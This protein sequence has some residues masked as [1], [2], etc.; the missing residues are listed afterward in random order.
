MLVVFN[1]AGLLAVSMDDGAGTS[2]LV[3]SLA[4]AEMGAIGV[5]LFF[6]ISGFVMALSARRFAGPWGASTFLALRFVRIAPLFYLA[7][8]LMLANLIRAGI[9]LDPSS[10]LNSI[11][12]IPLF[13][14]ETYSWPLHYL[15]WTLSFEFA[16]YFL[17]CILIGRG[18]GTKPFVLLALTVVTPFLGF[19]LKAESAAWKIFTNPILWEFGLGVLAY[20]LWER[21]QMRR[22]KALFALLS[23]G[24]FLA[25]IVALWLGRDLLAANGWDGPIGGASGGSETL[26][27]T[28]SPLRVLYWGLPMFL[29]L[30]T[31]IGSASIG[32]GPWARLM[33]LLGDASYSIYLSHLFVIMV[34]EALVERV[35]IH[36]DLVVVAALATSALVGVLVYRLVEKPMLTKG[37][38][39]VRQ[40]TLQYARQGA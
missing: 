10:L 33:K 23:A 11:T 20:I 7:S 14:D 38:R 18:S 32:T 26:E 37:Q 2:W 27:G 9:E 28:T 4:V 19:L 30:C 1:H 40:W 15:G 36:P 29:A 8:A 31:A 17:V 21:C 6:V 12:F 22:L 35:V 34:M 25:L 16:F 5:D 13:D 3:P 24:A 39:K